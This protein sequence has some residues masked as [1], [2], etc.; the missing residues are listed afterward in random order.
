MNIWLQKSASIQPRTRLLKFEESDH[1]FCR[2]QFGSHAELLVEPAERLVV[3]S[4]ID[5]K[6]LSFTFTVSLK[7][8]SFVN[9]YAAGTG[10]VILAS[11]SRRKVW[12]ECI[13]RRHAL[14]EPIT[15]LS[16]LPRSLLTKSSRHTSEINLFGQL[17]GRRTLTLSLILI[18]I[19]ILTLTLTL[20]L[21]LALTL[22]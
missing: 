15:R 2:S 11:Y 13:G 21:T 3:E 7:Y 4:Q 8:V 5:Q 9:Q 16:C 14:L 19:L 18:L 10:S 12:F 1:R 20:T 22:S 17:S 6:Q